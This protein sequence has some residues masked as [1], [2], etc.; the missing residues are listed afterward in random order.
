MNS[1]KPANYSAMFAVLNTLM[2]AGRRMWS[3]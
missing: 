1:R 3:F 2:A